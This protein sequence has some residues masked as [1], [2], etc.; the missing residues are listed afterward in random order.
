MPLKLNVKF[1]EY[2]PEFLHLKVEILGDIVNL[3]W[4][5]LHALVYRQSEAGPR[6]NT[7]EDART[8]RGSDGEFTRRP[9]WSGRSQRATAS[10]GQRS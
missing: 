4:H 1:D 8:E 5:N 9:A 2:F 10:S 7:K 6:P 3:K